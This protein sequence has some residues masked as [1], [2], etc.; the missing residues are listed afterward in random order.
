LNWNS[1]GD[2]AILE[3]MKQINENLDLN[4]FLKRAKESPE[5][6]LLLDYDGTLAPFTEDRDEAL[7]YEGVEE[8]LE[9][10]LGLAR[11]RTVIV[12]GRQVSDI[13]RL[14]DLDRYPEIW[15]CHG[16]E[17][18]SINGEYILAELSEETLEA[19]EDG[20]SRV[21][22]SGLDD[23]CEEKPSS[24]AIHWRGLPEKEARR[25]RDEVLR[26][27]DD[28]ILEK[29]LSVHEFDGGLELR[30]SRINKSDVVGR[31]LAESSKEASMIYMGDDFTD[32]DAFKAL[33]G[34]GLGVLVRKEFRETEADIWIK[35][36]GELLRFLAE[37]LRLFG[38]DNEEK[39]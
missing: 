27:W 5:M 36:P 19:L 7:P 4:E 15:G 22:E 3:N 10:L 30:P 12:S 2:P 1:G 32:E 38:D 6:I 23:R 24:L 9:L 28:S 18:I 35:P 16:A 26:I 13:I 21:H 20:S 8:I 34:R 17:R 31:I 14:L 29:G 11:L 39:E 37:L 25:I 33:K